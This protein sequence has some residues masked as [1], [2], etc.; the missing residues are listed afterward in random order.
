MN[1][2]TAAVDVLTVRALVTTATYVVWLVGLKEMF[3]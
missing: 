2:T 3:R 1:R